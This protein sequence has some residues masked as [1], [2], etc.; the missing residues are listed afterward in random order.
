MKQYEENGYLI[1]EYENGT[2]IKSIISNNIIN[3]SENLEQIKKSKQQEIL[4]KCNDTISYSFVSSIKDGEQPYYLTEDVLQEINVLLPQA[5]EGKSVPFKNANQRICSIWTAQEFLQFYK[6]A[7]EF[8]TK[9]KFYKDGLMEMIDLA[10]TVEEVNTIVW[11]T[12][13]TEDIQARIN[14]TIAQLMA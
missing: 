11:G 12:I 8:G 9:T 1:T 2:I 10:T 7:S 14:E 13:L 6:E 4:N 5:K 3:S